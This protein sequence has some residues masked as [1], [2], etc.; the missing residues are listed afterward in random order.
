[1]PLFSRK[2]RKWKNGTVGAIA[3]PVSGMIGKQELFNP[4]TVVG[5]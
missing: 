5:G 3:C 4:A 2:I 1:M